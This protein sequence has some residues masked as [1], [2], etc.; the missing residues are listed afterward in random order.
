[1]D[2]AIAGID[3][4]LVGS[5]IREV[6]ATEVMPRWRN[7]K[8]DDVAQKTGPEDLVTVADKAAELAL[9]DRLAGLLA[10]SGVVGEEAVAADATILDRFRDNAPLWVIDPIDGTQAFAT[11]KPEFTVMVGLV[12]GKQPVAGWIYAPAADMMHWAVRGRGAWRAV[13]GKDR[14]RLEKPDAPTTLAQCRGIIG[15]RM[16]T[17]ERLA[18][19]EA[20]AGKFAALSPATFAGH[21]YPWLYE[22][23]AHFCM[24]SK[25]EPWDHLPGLAIA[26]ELGL[27]YGKYDGTT[28]LPGDNRGG[29]L[30]GHGDAQLA[31]LRACLLGT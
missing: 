31:T 16:L 18:H 30:V 5:I 9:T 24:F 3:A 21:Q 14:Q 17:A 28:Y 26:S 25:S 2:G 27:T 13:G 8:A 6:A 10:G 29:L 23:R 4:D 22:G 7:L 19:I 1:M 11:G 12:V 20:Q 15:R